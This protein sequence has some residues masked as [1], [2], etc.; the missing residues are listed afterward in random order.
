MREHSAVLIGG[1]NNLIT[2]DMTKNLPFVRRGRNWI[3]DRDH[4]D[5]GW[6]L[7]ASDDLHDTDDYA[8]ITRLVAKD[9]AA[10][11]VAVA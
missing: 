5:K 9:D 2:R 3:K 8:I 7:H 6:D 10:P 11:M 1:A 4:P